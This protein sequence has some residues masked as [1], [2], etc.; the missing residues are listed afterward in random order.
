MFG[1]ILC[2]AVSSGADDRAIDRPLTLRQGN[3]SVTVAPELPLAPRGL[4]AHYHPRPFPGVLRDPGTERLEGLLWRRLRERHPEQSARGFLTQPPAKLAQWLRDAAAVAEP[5]TIRILALRVDFLEDSAGDASTTLDGGFDLRDSS[6]VLIDPP[7]HNRSY[8][9]S[10]FE[11]LRRYYLQQSGGQVVLTWDLF[12]AEEDSVY[13][14]S[15]TADYGP[16]EMSYGSQY[17]LDLAERLVRDGYALADTC[18]APPDFRHYDSFCLIHAGSDFQGDINYDSSYDIPSF[19]I[20]LA[21]PVAVQDSSFFIDLILV[22]PES[23]SQDGFTGAL[24]GVMA[25]E[26]GHQLGFYDLYHVIN[27][28][29]MVGMFSLMDSGDQLYGQVQ[30]TLRNEIVFVRGAMPASIDPWTKMLFFPGGVDP[31]WITA[32]GTYE[33]PAVQFSNQL[34]IV[35]IGGHGV[36]EDQWYSDPEDDGWRPELLASEYFILENRPYDLNGDNTIYLQ[37]DP[38]TGVLLGPANIDSTVTDS[39]GL[40]PDTLGSYEQ[41]FLLPGSGILIWHVDN[42]AIQAAGSVCYGCINI[43]RERPGVDVEEADGIDDLGDVYSVQWTGG[44]HDYWYQGGYATLGV[45]TRPNSSSGGG[46]VTGI[47]FEV[48]D[49]ADVA[50]RVRITRS[51][52]RAG[53]PR[54]IAAPA[55]P[56][57]INPVDLDGDG[58]CEIVTGGG[59]SIFTLAANGGAYA[60]ARYTDGLFVDPTDSLLIPGVAVERA[61]V[62]A[63]GEGKPLLAAATGTRVFGW[64][65]F[66]VEVLRY[67]GGTGVAPGLRFTTAPMLLDSVLVIG[68]ADGRLRGLLPGAANELLWRTAEAGFPATALAAGD[69]YGVAAPA[70]A[71]GDERGRLQ[72]ATGSQ[73]IGYQVAEGWPQTLP[74]PVSRVAHLLLCEDSLGQ[75]GTLLVVNADGLVALYSAEGVLQEGWPRTLAEPPAGPPVIGDPD[76][77]GVLEIAVTDQGGTIHLFT[78]AGVEESH[79]PRSVWHADEGR[80]GTVLAGPSIADVTGDGIPEILQGSADGIVHA[81]G[82]GGEQVTGWPRAAGYS[83]SA[84]PMVAPTG[85]HG[86]LQVLAADATGFMTILETGWA[87]REPR[88][89]EMWRGDGGAARRH[90]VARAQLPVATGY[91]GLWDEGS[92]RFVPNPVVGRQGQLRVRMGVAGTLQMRLFDTSGAEVWSGTHRV[93]Q[94]GQPVAWDLDLSSIA[95]GLYVA[96]IMVEGGGERR[97]TMRK[98]ALVR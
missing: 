43:S 6:D 30:D 1:A 58:I 19:N 75:T 22:V 78:F 72:V 17:I 85:P 71:W 76:G 34:L 40:P 65:R 18:P 2:G 60:H 61:F 4:P 9:E 64:D 70:L 98:L 53:W 96:Q 93:A 63:T 12:P 54:Y 38:E 49:S 48:L 13:H 73:R 77:D 31:L 57:V 26:F 56:A 95:P 47:Q 68:D 46:G 29:P 3:A 37:S 55:S 84:G 92:L 35:P 36:A 51:G 59:T 42:A 91:A 32:D 52:I 97:Q 80:F 62:D 88:P 90:A 41:D 15:D 28:Y 25:H 8:F 82:G 10:H 86:G 94:I 87:A 50:M 83:L 45:D 21:D 69:L 79:W 44:A 16:W 27:F 7:P 81:F 89:G 24:N 11:A 33:L 20:Y 67:P 5:D 23:V 66:G 74:G 14:L 39:L